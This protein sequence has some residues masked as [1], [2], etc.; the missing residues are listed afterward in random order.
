MHQT[1]WAP[2]IAV[3]YALPEQRKQFFDSYAKTR[4]FDPLVP[5]NWYN[6]SQANILETQVPFPKNFA[7]FRDILSSRFLTTFI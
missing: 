2:P 6:I 5:E 7:K 3:N 1:V 4:G